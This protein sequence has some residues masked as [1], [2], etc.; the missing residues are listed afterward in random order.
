MSCRAARGLHVVRGLREVRSALRL[1]RVVR[2]AHELRHLRDGCGCG[3]GCGCC[4][5]ALG[6]LNLRRLR[7]GRLIQLSCPLALTLTLPQWLM[8]LHAKNA[9]RSSAQ[10]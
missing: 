6:A 5:N 10:P 8:N 4:L 3:C 2:E 7:Q 1:L 9:I